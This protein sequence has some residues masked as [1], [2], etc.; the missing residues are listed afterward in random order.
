MLNDFSIIA[1]A[2]SDLGIPALLVLILVVPG[3]IEYRRM[4]RL[5]RS[6]LATHADLTDEQFLQRGSFLPEEAS[7]ALGVRNACARLMGVPPGRVDPSEPLDHVFS[8]GFDGADLIELIMEIEDQ[9]HVG[10]P[11]SLFTKPRKGE[12]KPVLGSLR[13]LV[14]FL[15]ENRASLGPCP[16]RPAR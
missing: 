9:L 1:W 11:D 13:D 10:I 8:F 16:R 15:Y 4:R 12:Q 2:W 6:H 14:G 5:K 3:A 7:F